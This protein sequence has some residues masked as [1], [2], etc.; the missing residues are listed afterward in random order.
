MV[1][2]YGSA[3]T[4]LRLRDS[5]DN[6]MIEGR[7]EIARRYERYQEDCKKRKEEL[8]GEKDIKI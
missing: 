4:V 8:K 2:E 3:V 6:D 7:T 5:F 1:E